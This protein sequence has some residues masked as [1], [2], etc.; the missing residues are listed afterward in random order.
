MGRK[1][2]Y[3]NNEAARLE[4]NCRNRQRYKEKKTNNKCKI[5][6]TEE[7][8]EIAPNSIPITEGTF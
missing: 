8:K 6:E 7:E 2:K 4:R 5:Q 1:R 3:I